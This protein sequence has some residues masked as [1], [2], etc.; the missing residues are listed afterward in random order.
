MGWLRRLRS[1]IAG[2][3]V[4]D[5][6]DEETRFHI[7]EL[8]DLYIQQGLPA[9]EARRRAQ[10]RFGNLPSTRE[11]TRD[12]DTFRWLTDAA[13]DL[14]FAARTLAKNPGFTAVAG[15]TLALGIGA[16][17][18][19]FTMVD[20]ILLRALPV[21]EPSR[22]VLFSDDIS[23]GTSSGDTPADRWELFSLDA[24]RYL[25]QQPLP[26]ESLAAVRSGEATVLVHAGSDSA[27]TPHRAQAHLVSGNYFDT[28]GV[29]AAIGRTLRDA[30]DRVGAGPVAVISDGY[31]HRRLNADPAVIGRAVLLNKTAFTI[32]GVT[33]PE[34]FGERVRR[35]PDIWVPLSFQPD[36]EARPSVLTR[37]DTYW[38]SLIGR[39]ANGATRA[40]AQTA[41]TT[42]IQQFLRSQTPNG[43]TA[44]REQQIRSARVELSSGATGLSNVRYFYSQPLRILLVVVGLVLLI[45]CANVANLLL[46]RASA[47]Q[48]ELSMRLALGAGRGR[49]IRQL[50]TESL[51]LAA[52][53]AAG[54]ILLALWVTK[55]LMSFVVSSTTPVHA[56]LNLPVL[57]FTLAVTLAAAIFFGVAPAVQASRIDLVTAIKSRSLRGGSGRGR[58]RG[59]AA[60]VALQIAMS[61]VLLVGAGLFGRS[62]INLV[63]HPLGFEPNPVILARLNPRLAGHTPANAIASYRTLYD[64]VSAMPGVASVTIARYS[65]FGGGRSVNTGAVEGYAPAKDEIV[66]I[67]A[68]HVGP[69]YP[70]TLGIPILA[71]RALD[72][73]DVDG[74]PLV[75]MVN[76]TFVRKYLPGVNPIGRHLG[77]DDEKPVDI[78]IVGVL[79]DAQ[80]HN[81]RE[82]VAPMAFIS[83]YQN[84]NQ[85]TLDGELE[86]RAAGDPAALTGP[87]RRLVAE[88]E[89]NLPLDDP[90][91]LRDQVS[92]AFDSQ[93]LAARFVSLFG[94]LALTLASIGLYGTIAQNV[95]Q[96]TNE[97]GIRM[98]LGAERVRVVWMI[99]R[100]TGVLLCIG[101]AIGLPAATIAARLVA[102]QLFALSTTDTFS[103]TLAVGV[104]LV[105]GLIAGLVPARRATKV[106]PL[107]ALRAE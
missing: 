100:Q 10:R 44:D 4:T 66:K 89:P 95:A 98:A 20:A 48:G 90:R 92:R 86:V 17:T 16:N 103:F 9:D 69:S 59:A 82:P 84:P 7:D 18:A 27:A 24:Y 13:Q 3:R 53:G 56:T 29:G 22:L 70:Q 11:R 101:L 93:R 43:S 31:R 65:P 35:P 12:A 8:T 96:R 14:R 36:I 19:I 91:L 58:S 32:V 72:V 81:P 88:I 25:R 83:F 85:F 68:I 107:V 75:G 55:G 105:V 51:L 60:L 64:R 73:R 54:G 94:L 77:L 80:F 26:F 46:T 33:P 52:L 74:G 97:I 30:D 37:S 49:L 50:I 67:E 21:R 34:F 42:A 6:F 102:S 5:E 76:E 61:L 62:L 28:M 41:A 87:L 40:Q 63:G 47:R 45:A 106:S 71:G 39:L 15:I 23:E 104:L 1:S 99:L 38:L 2:T 79:K 78:E 57:L